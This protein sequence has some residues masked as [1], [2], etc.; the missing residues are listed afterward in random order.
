MGV[1]LYPDAFQ[2]MT[3]IYPGDLVNR[4]V[5]HLVRTE[6]QS[7][8]VGANSLHFLEMETLLLAKRKRPYL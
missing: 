3:G 7:K 2:R 5:P 4:T 1:M 8:K 6:H